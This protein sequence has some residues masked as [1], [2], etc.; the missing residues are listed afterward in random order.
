MSP[1]FKPVATLLLQAR[2]N[3]QL[4]CATEFFT[5]L[6]ENHVESVNCDE[7]SKFIEE[8]TPCDIIPEA[9]RVAEKY[10]LMITF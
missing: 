6:H 3:G 1:E 4:T 10:G 9:R 7:M 8:I 5:V 2:V